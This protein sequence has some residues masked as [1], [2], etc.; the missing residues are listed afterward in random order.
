[1][2]DQ[3]PVSKAAILDVLR[4][5]GEDAARRLRALPAER[6]E[7]GRYENGWNGRQILAHV[8]AIEWTYPRLL[9]I[10]KQAR[11]EG[12]GAGTPLATVH[13][14]MDAYNHRQ[15][16]RRA[17]ASIADLIAEFEA[18]RTATIAAVAAA[19]EDLFTRHI[20]SAGGSTGTLGQVIHAV[21]VQHMLG[22]VADI[23]GA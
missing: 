20:R 23:E 16:E 9:E 22:H 15:V 4:S 6:Y 11:A 19:P 13:G 5:S 8:A 2:N 10:P 14:G 3:H 7:H 1:M 12:T 21:A 17:S 18:N